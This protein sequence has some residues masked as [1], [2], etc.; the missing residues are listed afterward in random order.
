MKDFLTLAGERYSCRRLKGGR[1]PEEVLNN[2]LEAGRCAP[3]AHNNQPVKIWVI[4]SQSALE[5]VKSTAEFPFLQAVDCILAVGSEPS[6]AWVRPFDGKNFADV[7][8]AIVTTQMM[9]AVQDLGLGTTWVGHFDADKLKA[10]FPEM[11]PYN[12]IALL[13]LGYPTEEARPSRLHEDRKS[14]EEY[15]TRL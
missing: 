9:L 5:K 2:I 3:T 1:I 13:P 4:E 7:D 14:K 15:F 12:L 8:A 10:Y 6:S 11:I